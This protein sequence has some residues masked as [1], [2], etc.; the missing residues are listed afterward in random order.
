MIHY[1][2]T[3]RGHSFCVDGLPDGRFQWRAKAGGWISSGS[4][5]CHCWGRWNAF[6]SDE[7]RTFPTPGEARRRADEAIARHIRQD[8]CRVNS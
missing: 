6:L 4:E 1:T 7:E 2:R 8:E 3:F 5:L